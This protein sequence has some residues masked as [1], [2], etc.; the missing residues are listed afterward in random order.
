M[1]KLIAILIFLFLI[2]TLKANTNIQVSIEAARDVNVGATF[3]VIISLNTNQTILSFETNLIY[4]ENKLEL[5][6]YSGINGFFLTKSNNKLTATNSSGRTGDF[7][8]IKLTFKALENFTA[9][10][11]SVIEFK[12]IKASTQTEQFNI[13]DISR[14]ITVVLPKS[15][16][17]KLKSLSIDGSSIANFSPSTTTYNLGTLNKSSIT[18]AAE[19]DDNKATVYGTGIKQLNYGKNTLSVDIVAENGVKTSYIIHVER[20]DPRSTNNFL[21]NLN[22]SSQSIN[23]NKNIL[24]YDLI[25]ENEIKVLFIS[26]VAEDNKATITGIGNQ[27]LKV[28]ENKIEIVVTA[29]NG[30]KKTYT[31][32]V[33]RK[34]EYGNTKKVNQST[35]LENLNLIGIE[36]LFDPNRT[37]YTVIVDKGI[38]NIEIEADALDKNS[39]VKI[40]NKDLE[41]GDNE[42]IIEVTDEDG[43]KTEYKINVIKESDVPIVK[44]NDA[45]KFLETFEDDIFEIIIENEALLKKEL[46][47]KIKEKNVTVI[48]TKYHESRVVYQW[49]FLGSRIGDIEE[50]NVIVLEGSEYMR[51]INLITNFAKFINLNFQHSG[52]LPDYTTFKTYV[53]DDYEDGSI[54]K[55][56]YYNAE[57]DKLEMKNN[58]VIVHEGY[59][60]FTMD[61]ASEYILTQALFEEEKESNLFWILIISSQVIIVGAIVFYVI[62]KKRKKLNKEVIPT[63]SGDAS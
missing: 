14:T 60:T 51:E 27:N 19:A 53:G 63:D 15:S 17:N 3:D 12:N 46:L 59:A 54:L 45:L 21:S 47:E 31:V 44:L 16:N 48:V 42:I 36:I 7:Q 6:D 33:I 25:V 49:T 40:I 58:N 13:E 23:F 8:I 18:I 39:K 38:T 28:Y 22:I 2:P 1:K 50:I 9:G 43:D 57:E 30:A 56:Y 4:D 35:M 34:D 37:N 62:S 55:L 32:N 26:A 52:K 5:R 10:E 61:H 20:F 11:G 29:E 24:N 41:V